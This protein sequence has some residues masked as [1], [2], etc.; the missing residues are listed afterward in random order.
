M[1]KY[2][3]SYKTDKTFCYLY[4]PRKIEEFTKELALT[5]EML[6]VQDAIKEIVQNLSTYVHEEFYAI[7][8]IKRVLFICTEK[9]QI[10]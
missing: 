3:H 7:E 6:P 5:C 4:S 10:V 8:Y 1:F 9:C 2:I